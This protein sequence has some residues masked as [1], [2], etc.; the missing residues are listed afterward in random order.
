MQWYKASRR[1]MHVLLKINMEEVLHSVRWKNR[2]IWSHLFVLSVIT[3]PHTKLSEIFMNAPRC[4]IINW[5]N[6]NGKLEEH[7]TRKDV[8]SVQ[9]E[10]YK[11]LVKSCSV[12]QK[13]KTQTPQRIKVIDCPLDFGCALFS[14]ERALVYFFHL[15]LRHYL[16]PYVLYSTKKDMI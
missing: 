2:W 10:R 3:V 6:A 5:C 13:K 9:E 1:Q 7:T 15:A 11:E 16:I 12:Q 14:H 4:K 8:I